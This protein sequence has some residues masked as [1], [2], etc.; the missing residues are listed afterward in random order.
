[1]PSTPV[2]KPRNR[3]DLEARIGGNW[4]NRIGVLAIFLGV[5]FFLKYAVDR[6]WIGST[7]RVL[8][9]AAIGI[10]FLLAGERLRRRYPSYAY[11][12]TGGG[13]AILYASIWFASFKR[14]GLLD[15]TVAFALMA[16]GDR[17]WRRLL[18]ARYNALAIAVLGLIGG[19]LTPI[20]FR[21]ELIMKQGCSLILR[22][23]M[24]ECWRLPIRNNGEA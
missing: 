18:A 3:Y 15:P 8:I 9:G 20:F 19:F 6:E 4:F 7:G 21:P 22:C 1:M 17:N 2:S 24:R 10:A 16:R 23:S 5:A 11:G 12:L 14:Y 13:I